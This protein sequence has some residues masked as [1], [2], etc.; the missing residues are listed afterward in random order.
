MVAPCISAPAL[1][2]AAAWGL[3]LLIIL[4]ILPEMSI[5]Q[6]SEQNVVH[7]EQLIVVIEETIPHDSG[8][9][10]QGLAFHQGRL[11][12]STGIR[13]ESTLREINPDNGE[14][15]RW[16]DLNETEFGEG[17]AIVDDE[18]V[19]L[20]WTSGHAYRHFFDTF[21]L[22]GNHTYDGEGWGLCHD[23]TQLVMS[24]GTDELTFRN[25]TT[26]DIIGS[27]NVTLNGT[28]LDKLNELECIEGL[29][30]ANV[31]QTDEIVVID[32]GNGVVVMQIDASGLLPENTTGAEVLNGI[33]WDVESQSLW[34]TGKKWPVMHRISLTVPSVD[35]PPV[36]DGTNNQSSNQELP[37]S[38]S[39]DHPTISIWLGLMIVAI[40][41][42]IAQQAAH[43]AM[44]LKDVERNPRNGGKSDDE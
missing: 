25:E 13:G 38:Q 22:V 42:L 7:P 4:S 36:D 26:F 17:I 11:F 32:P 3:S 14:V 1:N 29:I 31:Y 19:M 40:I 30:Y 12:E 10:T 16:F 8:A 43:Q 28:S 33:A 27:I 41:V 44:N 24:D 5:S 2:R 23:G 18:I 9:Y 21:E 39:D 15:L 20:T 34:V 6:E 37:L 35:L